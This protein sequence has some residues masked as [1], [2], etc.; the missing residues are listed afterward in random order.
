MIIKNNSVWIIEKKCDLTAFR[1]QNLNLIE[2]KNNSEKSRKT[3]I[4]MAG[5]CGKWF[6]NDESQEVEEKGP[7]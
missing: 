4:E 1:F 6:K 2:S 7:K 5:W 3:K